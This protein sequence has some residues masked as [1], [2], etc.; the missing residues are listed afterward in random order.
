MNEKLTATLAILLAIFAFALPAGAASNADS[1]ALSCVNSRLSLASSLRA[2]GEYSLSALEYRRLAADL[3][4]GDPS[5][6][7]LYLSAADAYR[8]ERRWDR[9][10]KML[11]AAE[12]AAADSALS[13]CPDS[14]AQSCVTSTAPLLYLRLRRAEGMRDWPSAAAYADDLAASCGDGES[15]LADWAR[16]SA[17]AN[18]L[19]ADG[20][21]GGNPKSPRIGGLLGII[22]GMGYAYSGEWGNAFRSIFLNGIFGWAMFEC[23]DHDRWGL[24]AI[25]TFFELTWYT[26]SIYGGIDAAHRY[27]RRQLDDA[28]KAI[29]GDGPAPQLTRDGTIGI[30]SLKLDF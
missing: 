26:G 22:P 18:R 12:D 5:L 8:L 3:E 11:D 24:F 4:P 29:T 28:A 6:P 17:S 27:N 9:M 14:Q 7:A 2:S 15:Q 19:R 25:T 1:Q 20:L 10:A 16:R 13:S 30:F 21:P 23:A